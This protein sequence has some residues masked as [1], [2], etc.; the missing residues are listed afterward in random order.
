M[1]TLFDNLPKIKRTPVPL[2]RLWSRDRK[3]GVSECSSWSVRRYARRARRAV[4]PTTA[5]RAFPP[6]PRFTRISPFAKS[7]SPQFRA[8]TSARLR[9]LSAIKSRSALSRGLLQAVTTFAS[10]CEESTGKRLLSSFGI[11]KNHG[12]EHVLLGMPEPQQRLY[13]ARVVVDRCGRFS[14]SGEACQRF[15]HVPRSDFRR[16]SE[17]SRFQPEDKRACCVPVEL[18]VA[19]VHCIAC[20]LRMKSV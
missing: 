16:S 8:H 6:L 18:K 9:P 10:S 17:A 12:V 1:L 5:L 14:S 7:T 20:R 11:S 19:S 13:G 3:S 15:A 2:R 4:A